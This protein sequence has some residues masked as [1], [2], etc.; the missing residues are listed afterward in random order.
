MVFS[1]LD[2]DTMQIDIN[3]YLPVTGK[4]EQEEIKSLYRK[5]MTLALKAPK[6]K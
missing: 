5:L 6:N 2:I 3:H 1:E 4:P